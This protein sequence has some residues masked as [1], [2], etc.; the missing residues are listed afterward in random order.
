MAVEMLSAAAAMLLP[1]VK[2]VMGMRPPPAEE[3]LQQAG[4]GLA[5]APRLQREVAAR[6]WLAMWSLQNATSLS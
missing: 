1:P 5:M 3:G 6:D 2:V 4:E